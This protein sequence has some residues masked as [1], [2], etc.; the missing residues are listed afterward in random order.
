MVPEDDGRSVVT[1]KV[2]CSLDLEVDARER[3]GH[4]VEQ[5]AD[6]VIRVQPL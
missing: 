3:G 4:Q 1:L 6:N 2:L 5:S